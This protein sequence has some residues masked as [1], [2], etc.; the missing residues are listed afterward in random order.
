VCCIQH[1]KKEFQSGSDLVLKDGYIGVGL[2]LNVVS[3]EVKSG[4]G[5]T[6]RSPQ[7]K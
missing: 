4:A 6:T 2:V 7:K 3:K 1:N 5:P